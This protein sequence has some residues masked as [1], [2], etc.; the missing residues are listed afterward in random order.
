MSIRAVGILVVAALAAG[1][2]AAEPNYVRAKVY[3]D[4]HDPLE[5]TTYTD[6]HGRQLQS[7][8]KR[9]TPT[10]G[11]H[12]LISCTEY[13]NEGRPIKSYLPVPHTTYGT[14]VPLATVQQAA[15]D[16][17]DGG[18]GEGPD[19]QGYPFAETRYYDDPLRRVKASGAP[20]KPFS[21]DATEGHP[22]RTWQFG[23]KLDCEIRW[24]TQLGFAK[25]QDGDQASRDKLDYLVTVTPASGCGADEGGGGYLNATHVLTVTM[26]ANGSFFQQIRDSFG[27]VVRTGSKCRYD[28]TTAHIDVRPGYAHDLLGRAVT[29]SS[30]A[31]PSGTRQL[32]RYRYNTLSQLKWKDGV[33]AD[34]VELRYDRAGRVV[35]VKDG[36]LRA[37]AQPRF[38]PTTVE[39]K[40]LVD[41]ELRYEYDQHGRATQTHV[42]LGYGEGGNVSLHRYAVKTRSVYDTVPVADNPLLANTEL[43]PEALAS[44]THTRGRPAIQV[45]YAEDCPC[46]ASPSA[47]P[48]CPDKVVEAFSYDRHGRLV[49]KFKSIP[50]LRLQKMAFEYD[51]QGKIIKQ[52]YTNGKAD[53]IT[54][55]YAYDA[56]GRLEYVSRDK[57]QGNTK[58]L[59]RY[60]YNTLGQL[61]STGLPDG[62]DIQ[63]PPVAWI[64]VDRNIRGWPESITATSGGSGAVATLW[65]ERLHYNAVG[66]AGQPTG[67]P[68]YNGNVS[69]V[70]MDYPGEVTT[71]P[72]LELNYEYDV[73][74]RLV[75]V[76]SASTPSAGQEAAAGTDDDDYDARFA[77]DNVGRFI[78]KKE[79]GVA[80]ETWNYQYQPGTNRLK[81]VANSPK[82]A[83]DNYVYDPN[84]NVVLDKSKRMAIL[85]DH[86]DL[87][88]KFIFYDRIPDDVGQGDWK[89]VHKLDTVHQET[90]QVVSYVKM[91]YDAAG[92]RVS[93]RTFT[94]GEVQ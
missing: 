72:S 47:E 90:P 53:P 58:G 66:G 91:L 89:I 51:R 81:S 5:A 7:Q 67:Q 50:G 36:N 52:Y 74:N 88:V 3:S 13:D 73:I 80:P 55:E 93:K 85:Y 9:N 42:D 64:G 44:L 16:W 31:D 1:A 21:L 70:E 35:G 56:D 54:T 37:L 32:T 76:T 65:S 22:V 45:A 94:P 68:Q 39:G 78:S 27:R 46:V 61:V 6:G 92:S 30:P 14:Y 8:A 4:Q 40:L 48:D 62:E 75:G 60:T 17:Y 26:D 28:G 24:F 71:Y 59:A 12:A 77:Y 38:A 19:A 25:V 2:G 82:S 15:G 10:G 20:G 18:A 33:D 83:D 57:S 84:A 11:F 79:R 87:P 41:A 23:V 63:Q 34:A 86:R 49:T 43:T 69:R 29:D